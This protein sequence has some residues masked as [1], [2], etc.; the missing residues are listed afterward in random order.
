MGGVTGGVGLNPI[1]HGTYSKASVI[2]KGIQMLN[3]RILKLL[4]VFLIVVSSSGCALALLDV[5]LGENKATHADD[6][7]VEPVE[8]GS[9]NF[10][11][12]VQ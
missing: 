1:R 10:S 7:S 12:D 9:N 11:K 3:R 6:Q 2:L 4:C 8:S 5:A